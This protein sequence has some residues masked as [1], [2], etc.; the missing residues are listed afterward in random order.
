MSIVADPTQLK[1]FR[2]T[3]EKVRWGT[4]PARSDDRIGVVRPGELF[5]IDTV[6]HEGLLEDQGRDPVAFFGAQGIHPEDVLQDAIDI[7][8]KVPH[9]QDTDGPH[10]LN[11]PITVRGTRPGDLLAVDI[12]E[13]APR[14]PYGVVSN[15]HGKGALAGELPRIGKVSSVFAHLL[16][17]DPSLAVMSRSGL[18]AVAMLRLPD[19]KARETE[20][21][22]QSR[23][24]ISFRIHPFLGIMGVTPDT[25]EH[26]NSVPPGDFGG[27]VD[28]NLMVAGTT[29]YLPVQVPGAG[30]FVGDPHFAQGDGEV[31]LTA[32]EASLQ[33][34][35]RIRVI[36]RDAVKSQFGELDGPL[37][38]TPELLVPTGRDR[39]LDVA[40]QRCTRQAI[41]LLCNRWGLDEVHAYAYLSAATDFNIS[42]AVDIVKGVHARIRKS[43]FERNLWSL[44]VLS[45][46]EQV[47]LS[48]D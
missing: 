2:A 17:T 21:Q 39:D 23:Y 38:E 11:R 46:A 25:D 3:A 22:A 4:L 1:L 6:S 32:L 34:T 29:L 27:N 8:R 44:D 30:F 28:I 20:R 45:A 37:I 12:V 26:L 36:P 35:L 48:S 16:S 47:R 33:A 42:E 43:D 9:D 13:L 10:I 7:A 15:R 18:D 41:S 19:E 31:S 14:V 40:L 24:P 5:Q